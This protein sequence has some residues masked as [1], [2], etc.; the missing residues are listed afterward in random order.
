VTADELCQNL[1]QAR[2]SISS[3]TL[4]LGESLNPTTRFQQAIAAHP[5]RWLALSALGGLVAARALVP[6]KSSRHTT[7]KDENS[8]QRAGL[9]LAAI[10]GVLA[11]TTFD[12]A[13][14]AATRLIQKRLNELVD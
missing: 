4:E 12:L 8:R 7:D 14:P 9:P 10:I 3:G 2:R 5:I 11:R 1:D 13:K 6:R